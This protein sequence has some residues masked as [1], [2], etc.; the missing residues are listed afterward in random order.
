MPSIAEQIEV[1]CK[2]LDPKP[3]QILVIEYPPGDVLACEAC[4]DAGRTI[5]E[6]IGVQVFLCPAPFTVQLVDSAL[7]KELQAREM[8]I[9]SLN[10]ELSSR[11]P[12]AY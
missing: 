8:E 12:F 3:G 5:S 9:E 11:L 2:I 6:S 7:M 4:K 10:R 1:Q